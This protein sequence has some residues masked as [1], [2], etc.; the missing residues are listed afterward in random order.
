V[1]LCG[2]VTSAGVV[3]EDDAAVALAQCAD[4]AGVTLLAVA[5]A[6]RPTTMK[7]RI[8]GEGQQLIRLDR[9]ARQPISGKQEALLLEKAKDSMANSDAVL[10]SD[11]GKGVITKAVRDM[12][13]VEAQRRGIPIVVDP[14]RSTDSSFP[15]VAV[16]TPSVLELRAMAA[17]LGSHGRTVPA[18]ARD[19]LSGFGARALL[20]TRGRQ[21]M[22]LYTPDRAVID[23]PTVADKVVNVAG[24]G[25]GVAAAL[26]VFLAAGISLPEACWGASLVA[27]QVVRQFDTAKVKVADLIAAA[28]KKV[29]SS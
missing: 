23:F 12:V 21:G 27:A 11:Y 13:G 2:S 20:V 14:C 15:N 4:S 18:I 29:A 6:A 25:D 28:E 26:A 19:V 8:F 3:G 10:I 17:A 7:T 9:E 5:D 16:L 24:A 1:G 22:T